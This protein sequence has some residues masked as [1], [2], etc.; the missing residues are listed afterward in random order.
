[1]VLPS[2]KPHHEEVLPGSEDRYLAPL[3]AARASITQPCSLAISPDCAHLAYVTSEDDIWVAKVGVE[4]SAI[5]ITSGSFCD[6][7][8][9]WSRDGHMIA[10][11][12]DRHSKGGDREGEDSEGED[13]E[14]KDSEGKDRDER[15]Q[16]YGLKLRGDCFWAN[17]EQ[18]RAKPT[19]L[20]K[21]SPTESPTGSFQLASKGKIE[22]LE[23]CADGRSIAFVY[24]PPDLTK[25]Y[26]KPKPKA[27][28]TA[29]VWGEHWI[30]SSV[31]LLDLD[32]G[33][34][35][36]LFQG[37]HGAHV[38]DIACNPN[39]NEIAV[40]TH[41]T[42]DIN[43]RFNP[44]A[45]IW[46]ISTDS[47]DVRHL[48]SRV[49]HEFGDG[50]GPLAW[51]VAPHARLSAVALSGQERRVSNRTLFFPEE[52]KAMQ[53]CPCYGIF[54][55]VE[56][57]SSAGKDAVVHVAC[58][59]YDELRSVAT[60]KLLAPGR[61]TGIQ[62]LA[63]H[64]DI[65]GEGVV[66]FVRGDTNKP[67]EVY[68]VR[69]GDGHLVR[70]S[71]HG[72][73]LVAYQGRL[74]RHSL[75]TC[76]T[77]DGKETIEAILLTPEQL[78]DSDASTNTS[79][80]TP[81]HVQFENVHP[82]HPMPTVVISH[83]GPYARSRPAS[84]AFCRV[85]IYDLLRAGIAVLLPNYRG[86]SGRGQRFAEYA[87]GGTG[88][89]DEDDVAALVTY[90]A[91]LGLI[92]TTQLVHGGSSAGGFLSYACAVR[93]GG[94]NGERTWRWRGIIARAGITDWD[95]FIVTADIPDLQHDLA[96]SST[97]SE[98]NFTKS[99]S[100]LHEFDRAMRA[101]CIPNMLLVHNDYDKRVP[102][103]QAHAFRRLLEAAGC[104]FKMVVY[105][106]EDHVPKIKANEVDYYQHVMQYVFGLFSMA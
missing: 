70:L 83:G 73:G 56:S 87:S 106:T 76:P 93:N 35:R 95:S 11:T 58:G 6:N 81:P 98:G 80:S 16:I 1:M 51:S 2:S 23:F 69:T 13:S 59:V 33:A 8:P 90:A 3:S 77:T 30:Y 50:S 37:R 67:D 96:V 64:L 44:G 88:K 105:R 97:D 27:K 18:R 103:S 26:S 45:D 41:E 15:P 48:A 86:S 68:S 53:S 36:T 92:D 102:I 94:V 24:T 78:V 104:P 34:V 49:I 101:G 82:V 42:P 28:C 31:C 79:L 5:R 19:P 29:Y 32:T 89:V 65:H 17:L 100:P 99:L 91:S 12:S 22:N 74:A 52:N 47:Q 84:A 38:K 62:F 66:A 72:T 7:A 60:G 85:P 43:A 9:Q 21:Y 20:I 54:N 40:R 10:F 25:P 46:I 55:C 61:T 71:N 39:T 14:G 75:L 63:A 57:V 4:N